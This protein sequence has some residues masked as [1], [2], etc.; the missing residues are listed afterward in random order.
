MADLYSLTLGFS[1]DLPPVVTPISMALVLSASALPGMV[2]VFPHSQS[3]VAHD[4]W[5]PREI[6]SALLRLCEPARINFFLKADF[7]SL[8][9]DELFFLLS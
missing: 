2:E 6:D 1:S 7:L 9:D 5:R 4:W 3:V 8:V